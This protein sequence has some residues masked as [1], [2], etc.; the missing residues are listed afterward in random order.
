MCSLCGRF[1]VW[2]LWGLH[3]QVSWHKTLMESWNIFRCI[4]RLQMVGRGAFSQST[5]TKWTQAQEDRGRYLMMSVIAGHWLGNKSIGTHWSFKNWGAESV[6]EGQNQRTQKSY[7][8]EKDTESNG[9]VKESRRVTQ[10]TRH[11]E[12]H[13]ESSRNEWNGRLEVRLSTHVMYI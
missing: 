9:P 7:G 6:H 5:G 3:W 2:P 10:D 12:P 4:G 1:W 8:G 13:A 11:R